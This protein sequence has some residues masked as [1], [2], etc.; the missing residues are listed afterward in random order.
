MQT[1]E[2]TTVAGGFDG[3]N[4]SEKAKIATDTANSI[5]NDQVTEGVGYN[6]ILDIVKDA[7]F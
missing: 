1:N 5:E 7:V 3:E 4:Y 6:R 2:I